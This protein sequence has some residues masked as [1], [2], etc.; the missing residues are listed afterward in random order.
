M[1]FGDRLRAERE[2][3]GYSQTNFAAA[4]GISRSQANYFEVG[5]NLPNASFLIEAEKIGVDVAYVLTGRSINEPPPG[6]VR[7]E[8]VPQ[9]GALESPFFVVFPDF[10]LR[11]KVGGVALEHLR[12]GLVP[13]GAME[14]ALARNAAIAIDV[15]KCTRED[16]IDGDVYAYTLAGRPDVRRIRIRKDHWTLAGPG[17]GGDSRDV[18]LSDLPALHVLGAVVALL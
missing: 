16:V 12:W 13:T 17:R 5:R 4:C 6:H 8:R 9:L 7:L 18:Y 2:R 10:V 1:S 15:S 11:D 3:L 14:P